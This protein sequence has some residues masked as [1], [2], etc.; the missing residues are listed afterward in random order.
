MFRGK[1]PPGLVRSYFGRHQLKKKGTPTGLD[2]IGKKLAETG[3]LADQPTGRKFRITTS[4]NARAFHTA[5]IGAEMY[6]K[7][8]GIATRGSPKAKEGKGRVLRE[9]SLE[10]VLPGE[11]LDRYKAIMKGIMA[12][13]G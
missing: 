12:K 8:G 11:K 10:H 13:I 2:P 1:I 4:T 7:Y 9:I 3:F 5:R 6:R